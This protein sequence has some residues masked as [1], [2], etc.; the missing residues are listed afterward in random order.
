MAMKLSEI[1]GER[2]FD[3]IADMIDPISKIAEDK[4]AARMFKREKCPEGMEPREFAIQKIKKSMP[5]LIK[6]HKRE[7]CE[8]L[9]AIEGTDPKEYM[10]NVTLL[11]LMKDVVELL[12]DDEF[13]A[14]FG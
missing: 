1:K 5:S 14:F 10:D 11:K 4:D 3:V 8:I 2:V 7:L 6:N 9:G 13:T 12:N